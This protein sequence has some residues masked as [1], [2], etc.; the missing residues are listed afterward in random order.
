MSALSQRDPDVAAIIADEEVRQCET[1]EMIAS[2]NYASAAA[3][4]TE[5]NGQPLDTSGDLDGIHFNDAIGLGR[6]LHQN[7]ATGACLVRRLYAYATG[8]APA[9]REMAWIRYLEK[10][11]S[12]S[13]Y[14]VPDLMRRIATSGNLYRV[15]EPSAMMVSRTGLTE[16]TSP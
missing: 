12:E 1:L 15:T 4:R 14:R 11:F 5:E 7:P 9:R 8:R 16:E 10:N 3:Y 6:A 13:G 2:E